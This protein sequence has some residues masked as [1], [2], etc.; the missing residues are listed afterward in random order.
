MYF[1][2]TY[3]LYKQTS[4]KDYKDYNKN[5][6]VKSIPYSIFILTVISR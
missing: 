2:Y 4:N 3:Q 1:I 5:I 6:F